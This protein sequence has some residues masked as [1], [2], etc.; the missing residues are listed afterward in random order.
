MAQIKINEISQNYQYNVGANSYATVALPITACW[1]PAFVDPASVGKTAEEVLEGSP[2]QRFPSTSAGV[3]SF[4]STYRGPAS[5]YR[6]INDYSYQMALTLLNAGYDILVNR[7]CPGT[8]A[9]GMFT[10]SNFKKLTQEPD[11]WTTNKTSYYK[12][13]TYK[14]TFEPITSNPGQE[15]WKQMIN[16]GQVYDTVS[17]VQITDENTTFVA[18][19]YSTKTSVPETYKNCENT[20]I[21]ITNERYQLQSPYMAVKAKYPGTFGNNLICKVNQVKTSATSCYWNLVVYVVNDAGQRTAVE[22]LVFVYNEDNSTDSIPSVNEIESNFITLIPASGMKDDDSS[23]FTLSPE[24]QLSLG[25]DTITAPSGGSLGLLGKIDPLLKSYYVDGEYLTAAKSYNASAVGSSNLDDII[26]LYHKTWLY[27]HTSDILSALSDKLTYNPDRI[28]SPGWDD[29]DITS[30]GGTWS[31]GGPDKISPMHKKMMEIAYLS[32]CAT[33]MLDIP[34]SATRAS[35]YNETDDKGYAQMLSKYTSENY[36][37]DATSIFVT[38]SALFGPWGKFKYAGMSKMKKASPS[39][40]ALMI[41][42]SMISNQSIQYKW[43]LPT[44]RRSTVDAKLDYNIP[45]NI[46]DQW[47]S[48][49]GVGVNAIINLPDQGTTVWGNSTLYDVPPAT[50]QALSNLSTRYLIN[51]IKDQVFRCGIAITFQYNN[52]QAYSAF[53]AGMSPLLTAMQNCGAI[54]DY[55]IRMSADIDA[56]DSVNAN[57]IVGKIYL[58][59][60][61]VVNDITVDLVALPT[62]VSLDQYRA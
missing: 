18:L 37:N 32:R 24:I 25:T 46:L 4:I 14:D 50:Y 9:Q 31:T 21:F 59:V 23:I 3:E 10:G 12:V 11:D 19:K 34:S 48:L 57:S 49:E 42:R 60:A 35:I 6:A 44:T 2:W 39:F 22:N 53:F 13:A 5:N 47:Q 51:A 16:A 1:G 15:Q 43:L 62:S 36:A 40:L 8:Y 33:A 55:Y 29:Q 20:D 7:L 58:S 41:E 56:L 28:V 30:V 27:V 17:H 45:K 38:N 61:G 52:E 54:D 26:K